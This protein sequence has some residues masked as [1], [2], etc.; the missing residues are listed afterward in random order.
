MLPWVILNHFNKSLLV[1]LS[2]LDETW[3]VVFSMEPDKIS[4]S[5]VFIMLP[6]SKFIL[7][8][9]FARLAT[10]QFPETFLLSD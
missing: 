10:I 3:P 8:S 5:S 7:L 6:G 1:T 2:E 9:M 4:Q